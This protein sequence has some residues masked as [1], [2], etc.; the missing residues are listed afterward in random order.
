MAPMPFAV[1]FKGG[2]AI[3][4]GSLASHSH[5]CVRVTASTAAR[6]FY[7]VREKDTRVIVYP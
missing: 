5:G 6:I 1:F 3:H 4:E 2:A 7:N